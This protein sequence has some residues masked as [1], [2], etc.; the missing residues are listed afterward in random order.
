MK[1]KLI[2]KYYMAERLP[3]GE[4]R[5]WV[6]DRPQCLTP[7]KHIE[8]HSPD[9]FNFGYAGSGPADLALSILCDWF[10][11]DP[12]PVDLNRGKFK[13]QALYQDFKWQFITPI[14]GEKF[15]IMGAEIAEFIHRSR[16]ADRDNKRVEEFFNHG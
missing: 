16:K 6:I 4:V 12:R 5:A 14:K 7:L 13:A 2:K 8:K 10:R 1:A 11:E 9:G 15:V 3:S